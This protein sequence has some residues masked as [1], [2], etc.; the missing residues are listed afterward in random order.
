M[1]ES[2]SHLAGFVAIY[3]IELRYIIRQLNFCGYINI[4][5]H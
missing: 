2:D 4:Y 5:L 1:G 3:R